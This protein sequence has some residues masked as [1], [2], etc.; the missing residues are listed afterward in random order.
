MFSVQ[1]NMHHHARTHLQ[2]G[3]EAARESEGDEEGKDNEES[4]G[5]EESDGDEESKG[6]PVMYP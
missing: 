2:V 3:N 5:D 4:E 6:A 1:S